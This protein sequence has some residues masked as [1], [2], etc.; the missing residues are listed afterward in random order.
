M[1][2]WISLILVA[3]LCFSGCS[4]GN[5]PNQNTVN[6]YY[7]RS[8]PN[9]GTYDSFFSSGVIGSES[10]EVPTDRQD[11]RYVLALYLQGP[12]DPELA[13]P[14]PIGCKVLEFYEDEGCLTLILS[15]MITSKNDMDLTLACACLA[16]T[17]LELT[18]AETIQVESHN[19]DGKVLFTRVFTRDN[20]L[21]IDDY[22]Q[23]PEA[24]ELPQ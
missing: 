1:K 13:S 6:F 16:K 17:C 22:T 4:Q 20:V 24:T 15:R 3:I 11:L 7:L 5:N 10:R 2:R 8:Y 12:S 14:F 23:P 19:L 21:L 18:D 9:S